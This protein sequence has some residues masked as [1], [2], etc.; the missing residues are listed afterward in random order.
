MIDRLVEA[1]ESGD[2]EEKL[3]LARHLLDG[4]KTP[5]LAA[6]PDKV[7]AGMIVLEKD[8]DPA[9]A[10]PGEC[11]QSFKNPMR[12]NRDFGGRLNKGRR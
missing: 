8:L 12:V 10:D 1:V 9:V 7:E 6:A 11:P 2:A 4:Y 5:R 3:K